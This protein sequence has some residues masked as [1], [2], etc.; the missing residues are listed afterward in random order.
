MIA[1]SLLVRCL[2]V[3]LDLVTRA[4][5]LERVAE[6]DLMV[7]SSSPNPI[8][9]TDRFWFMEKQGSIE[10]TM[11]RPDYWQEW[12]FQVFDMYWLILLADCSYTA[13]DL[14][15]ET[16]PAHAMFVVVFGTLVVAGFM[17]INLHRSQNLIQCQIHPI[18]FLAFPMGFVEFQH[19]NLRL[20]T[21]MLIVPCRNHQCL[22]FLRRTVVLMAEQRL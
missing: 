17:I 8:K 10:E 15:V 9:P 16:Y 4:S 1:S 14:L 18:P 13:K 11:Q 5:V 21:K 19:R 2:K 20:E 3:R 6:H 7:A 12:L 22:H